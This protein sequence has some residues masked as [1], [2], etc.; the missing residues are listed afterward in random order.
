MVRRRG[1]KQALEKVLAAL[2]DMPGPPTYTPQEK[3]AIRIL[4]AKGKYRWAVQTGKDSEVRTRA[5][6]MGVHGF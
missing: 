1:E 3:D 5:Q 4:Q 6:G 2:K